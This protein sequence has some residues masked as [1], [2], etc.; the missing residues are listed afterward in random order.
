M[1]ATAA[2]DIICIM[3]IDFLITTWFPRGDHQKVILSVQCLYIYREG[4]DLLRC[5]NT[6]GDEGLYSITLKGFRVTTTLPKQAQ[7]T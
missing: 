7:S 3:S 6:T 2:L 5:A 1:A 4:D